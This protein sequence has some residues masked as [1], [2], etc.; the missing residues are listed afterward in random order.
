MVNIKKLYVFGLVT[1]YRE[2][3]MRLNRETRGPIRFR[4]EFPEWK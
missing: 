3:V 1:K 2:E 4:G